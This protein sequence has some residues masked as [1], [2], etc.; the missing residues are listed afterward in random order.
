MA[1]QNKVAQL[2]MKKKQ[3]DPIDSSEDLGF[4]SPL[5]P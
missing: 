1:M 5:K 4:P 3:T 2:M